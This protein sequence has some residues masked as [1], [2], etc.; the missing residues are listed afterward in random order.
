MGKRLAQPTKDY[1]V[2]DSKGV[3]P[4][5]EEGW[6]PPDVNTWKPSRARMR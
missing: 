2:Y 4:K 6:T 1:S 5:Q 3:S